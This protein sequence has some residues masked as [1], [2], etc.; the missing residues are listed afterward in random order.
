MQIKKIHSMRW[1]TPEKTFVGLVA[2]TD[3]GDN[4]SIGTPYSPESIIWDAVR[5]FPVEQI[6]DYV[7][8]PAIEEDAQE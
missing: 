3:T 6:S 4:E 8:P 5:E 7:E 2:D 1:A